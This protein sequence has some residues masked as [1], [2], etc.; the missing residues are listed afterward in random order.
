MLFANYIELFATKR[1]KKIKMSLKFKLLISFALVKYSVSDI[2]T[3]FMNSMQPAR[4]VFY[5]Y[6]IHSKS[7]CCTSIKS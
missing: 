2:E 5:I 1:H 3:Y 4:A 6:A 7:V